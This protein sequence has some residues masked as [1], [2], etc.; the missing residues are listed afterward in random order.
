MCISQIKESAIRVLSLSINVPIMKALTGLEY[1][2]K[3]A[4]VLLSTYITKDTVDITCCG[5]VIPGLGGVC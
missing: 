1:V 2:L 4:Q 3:R 5:V